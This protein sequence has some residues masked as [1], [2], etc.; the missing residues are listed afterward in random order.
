MTTGEVVIRVFG[1]TDVGRTREHNEDAFV[2]TDL[3]SPK[4]APISP[5]ASREQTYVPGDRG[6]L[7]MVA[8][9]MG[10]AAAGE[11]ASSMAVDAVLGEMR[12]RWVNGPA[13]GD[14]VA[15]AAALHAATQVANERIHRYATDHPENRGMGTTATVAGVLGDTLYIAQVGDSRAYLM[16]DGQAR[17]ITKDQSLMQR[18]IEA[19]EITAEEAEVSE[20]RNIILQALGPEAYIKIDI[21]HQQLRRGDILVLCSDGLSGVVRDS[22]IAEIV[23]SSGDLVT[24]CQRL[25]ARANEAGGPDNITVIAAEFEGDGLT[26]PG[27]DDEVG[28]RQFP[29][30]ENTPVTPV[31]RVVTGEFPHPSAAQPAD[32]EPRG[33]PTR[34]IVRPIDPTTSGSSALPGLLG[35]L[36]ALVAVLAALFLY[37]HRH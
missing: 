10:G 34:E 29:V 11:I 37:L 4:P 8:D 3:A 1:I 22:E 32:A 16:R 25:I 36:A 18:L 20:R 31:P 14:P 21:T 7:F 13:G 30:G 24:I 15:F 6:A 2:V 33:V 27:A 35:G 26:A 9:G 28:H 19:G 23:R 12:I 17:Q 5:A